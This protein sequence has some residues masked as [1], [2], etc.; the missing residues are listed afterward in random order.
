MNDRPWGVS[1][2]VGVRVGFARGKDSAERHNAA[3]AGLRLG[4]DLF[5]TDNVVLDL[6][7]DWSFCTAKVYPDDYRL[8]KSDCSFRMGIDFHF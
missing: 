7:F 8:E 6:A 1:P 5:L 4:L 3:L 2:Y